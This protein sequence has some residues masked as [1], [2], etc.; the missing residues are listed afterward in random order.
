MFRLLIFLA[1]LALAAWGL[2]W[3]ADNPGV[4]TIV[5]RGVEYKLSLML[6]LGIMAA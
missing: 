1:L 2:M 5:W 3:L 6:A 4:V